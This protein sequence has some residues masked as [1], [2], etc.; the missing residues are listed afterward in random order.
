MIRIIQV[1]CGALGADFLQEC[2]RRAEAASL[3]M[4]FICIDYDVVEYPRNCVSQAF[5]PSDQGEYKVD[6]M[7]DRLR[8]FTS[9]VVGVVEKVDS[10]NWAKLITC[11]DDYTVV[12]DCVDNAETRQLLW[13]VGLSLNCPVLHLGI[14]PKGAGNVTW[15]YQEHDSFPLSPATTSATQLAAVLADAKDVKLPPCELNALRSLILN[16]VMAGVAALFTALGKDITGEFA[17]ITSETH[18]ILS[19]W[20]TDLNQL[21]NQR[22]LSSATEL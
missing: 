12:V 21:I 15:N 16:T 4:E 14:S 13:T 7:A 1:G 6:V 2:C 8:G 10:K 18:G 17:D 3:S 20:D 11:N 9:K 19:V 22:E 5:L